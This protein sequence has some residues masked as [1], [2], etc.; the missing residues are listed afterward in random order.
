MLQTKQQL[1]PNV[2]LVLLVRLLVA[3]LGLH[4]HLCMP[5]PMLLPRTLLLMLLLLLLRSGERLHHLL[6]GRKEHKRNPL[7][8]HHGVLVC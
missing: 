7:R 3:V 1:P 5:M 8:R 6:V 2:L 4:L